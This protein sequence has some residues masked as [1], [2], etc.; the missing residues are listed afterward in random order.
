MVRC[1]VE[2]SHSNAEYM[3]WRLSISVQP[4]CFL[5]Q[6]KKKMCV[7]VLGAVCLRFPGLTD[8][9]GFKFRLDLVPSVLNRHLVNVYPL[10]EVL[11]KV[12]QTVVRSRLCGAYFHMYILMI[13][14]DNI[15]VVRIIIMITF[16]AIFPSPISR[17]R[18]PN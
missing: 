17:F 3:W 6:K 16:V 5:I 10:V 4:F 7:C 15:K 13:F 8:K 2:I 1:S 14:Y 11:G 12:S 9:N 18:F